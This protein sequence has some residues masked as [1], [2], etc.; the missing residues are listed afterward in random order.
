MISAPSTR[1][2]PT[3]ASTQCSSAKRP[4][5]HSYSSQ[6]SIL[7]GG[8]SVVRVVEPSVRHRPTSAARR[9][10]SV[11]GSR[12]ILIPPQTAFDPKS[13]LRLPKCDLRPRGR[14]QDA[15]PAGWAFP[16]FE[17]YGG[18]EQPRAFAGRRDVGYLDVGQPGRSLVLALDDAALDPFGQ[19]EREVGPRA[20]ANGVGPP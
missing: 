13:E 6:A 3:R 8:V 1:S 17:Y 18:S 10:C 2:S 16:R 12:R 4:G 11:S 7:A 5:S 9:W 14:R 19:L 15:A 20:D